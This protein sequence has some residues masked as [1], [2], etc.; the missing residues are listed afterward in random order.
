[1]HSLKIIDMLDKQSKALLNSPKNDVGANDLAARFSTISSKS[2]HKRIEWEKSQTSDIANM[3]HELHEMF[4]SM[5]DTLA[6]LNRYRILS[7]I[8]FE[9]MTDRQY[10][11]TEADPE[12]LDWILKKP[13]SDFSNH[14]DLKMTFSDWLSGG[15]GVFNITG[16][17]GSGKSTLMKHLATRRLPSTKELLRKN[18][19]A[20]GK[21]VLVTGSY[22]WLLGQ[23]KEQRSY[24]GLVRYILHELLNQAAELI[25][26]VFEKYWVHGWNLFFTNPTLEIPREEFEDAFLKALDVGSR[27]YHFC[28]FIDAVDE[29]DDQKIDF[30]RLARKISEWGNVS[31]VCVFSRE[32]PAFMDAFPASQRIRLHLVNEDDIRTMVRSELYDHHQFRK[33]PEEDCNALIDETVQLAEGVFLWASLVVKEMRYKLDS[34]QKIPALRQVLEWLPRKLEDCFERIL[35]DRI[36]TSSNQRESCAILQI[37]GGGTSSRG[38]SQFG[39]W[40]YSRVGGFVNNEKDQLARDSTVDML[41]RGEDFQERIYELFRGLMEPAPQS[42]NEYSPALSLFYPTLRFIHRSVYDYLRTDKAKW[43]LKGVAPDGEITTIVLKCLLVCT[44]SVPR[45]AWTGRFAS[46]MEA[47]IRDVVLWLGTLDAPVVKY[48]AVIQELE[49][50]LRSKQVP[51]AHLD[52]LEV[53]MDWG[54]ANTARFCDLNIVNKPRDSILTLAPLLGVNVSMSLVSAG[55]DGSGGRSTLAPQL[56]LTRQ[57][58]QAHP[59]CSGTPKPTSVPEPSTIQNPKPAQRPAQAQAPVAERRNKLAQLLA[60]LRGLGG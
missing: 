42:V 44:K 30:N 48:Q 6:E 57:P 5:G 39:L 16:K 36:L 35:I 2:H 38:I 56:P 52:R 8:R 29:L 53:Q 20:D 34:R 58:A 4:K 51:E 55:T 31:Q 60:K 32:E 37:A 47:T 9:R 12:T 40:F 10:D 1:M 41:G 24:T 45:S 27:K 49:T 22:L 14:P 50:T 33:Q 43:V 28:L 17:P 46:H 26:V 19:R 11:I 25:E 13:L 18:P 15:E 23:S 54:E 3:F 7:S 21:A 59:A